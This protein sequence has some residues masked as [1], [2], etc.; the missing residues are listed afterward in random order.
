MKIYFNR[1]NEDINIY[2][3]KGSVVYDIIDKYKLYYE[4]TNLDAYAEYVNKLS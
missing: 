3:F 1:L 2:P 4:V